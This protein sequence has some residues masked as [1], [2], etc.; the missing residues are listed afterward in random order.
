[1]TIKQQTHNKHRKQITNNL[2]KLSHNSSFKHEANAQKL[3]KFN[4]EHKTGIEKPETKLRNSSS[5]E[6]RH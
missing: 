3:N 4:I 2:T 1:M 6:S 5:R